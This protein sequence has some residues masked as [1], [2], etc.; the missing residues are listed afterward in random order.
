M[1]TVNV[2]ALK[3]AFNAYKSLADRRAEL[4]SEIDAIGTEMGELVATMSSSLPE[5]TTNFKAEGKT[6]TPVVGGGKSGNSN[7][8]RGY[9][10]KSEKTAKKAVEVLDLDSDA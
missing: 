5:G 3:T 9:A 8:L 7:F 10:P 4:E 1:S 6:L 2:I